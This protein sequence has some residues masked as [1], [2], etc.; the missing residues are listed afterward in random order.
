MARI[1]GLGLVLGLT[2][3]GP[4]DQAAQAPAFTPTPIF[5]AQSIGPIAGG[6]E[7]LAFAPNA[8][9][10]WEGRLLVAPKT[11]GLQVFGI[12]G[13]AG[14]EFAGPVY[15]SLA[16]QPGFSLRQLKI[17]IALAVS[18]DGKLAPLIIDD[19]RGQVFAAPIA[20]LPEQAVTGVCPLDSLPALPKFAI[21]RE[22]GSFELWK[23]EDTGEELLQAKLE[24]SGKL[25]VPTF[26]CAASSGKI[27][28]KGK[29]GG[30]F[31]I[32]PSN[33][34]I[35]DRGVD[36]AN[37]QFI[38]VS[39]DETLTYLLASD[40][41]SGTLAQFDQDL[42]QTGTLSA[43]ASLSIPP[44]LVP[45]AMAVSKWSFGGAGFSAGLLAVA[46]QSD[47]RISLIVRDTLPG[48]AHDQEVR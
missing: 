22:D 8:T 30:V 47:G 39:P 19:A 48:F 6:V 1:V 12:E 38:A 18:Q 26:G 24:N 35:I 27:Y 25:A 14:A 21:T 31:F 9:I 42:T 13:K 17:S 15:T 23:I 28:A 29:N 37:T 33:R 11:G 32:D 4:T 16:V 36:T 43:G 2:A 46:D 5:S 44:V 10:P 20:G 7:A 34:P 41:V 40:G 3:C 45:G